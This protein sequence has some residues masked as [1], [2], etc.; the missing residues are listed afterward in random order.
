[1]GFREGWV[2]D[3]RLVQQRIEDDAERTGSANR[4]LTG[5]SEESGGDGDSA[6]RV[7]LGRTAPMANRAVAVGMA[8]PLEELVIIFTQ[9]R[10]YLAV[11]LSE[12]W[13]ER[14]SWRGLAHKLSR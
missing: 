3:S 5:F 13:A 8:R 4:G 6:W 12:N 9:S 7:A 14:H 2:R 10:G 1:M 11:Y